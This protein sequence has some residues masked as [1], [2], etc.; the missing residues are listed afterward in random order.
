[1]ELESLTNLEGISKESDFSKSA[2][3]ISDNQLSYLEELN[4]P[5]ER[6]EIM[7]PSQQDLLASRINDRLEEIGITQKQSRFTIELNVLHM[8]LNKLNESRIS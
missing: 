4:V 2:F 8:I 3:E 5:S 7:S 6:W 1:M